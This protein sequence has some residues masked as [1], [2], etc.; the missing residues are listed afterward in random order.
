LRETAKQ[1]IC[2]PCY[3]I[4]ASEELQVGDFVDD[5]GD[6]PEFLALTNEYDDAIESDEGQ[7]MSLFGFLYL[8]P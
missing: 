7:I 2:P 5:D 4:E 1:L 3:F 8:V 6:A